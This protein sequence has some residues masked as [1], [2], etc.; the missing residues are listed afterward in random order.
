M[1]KFVYQTSVTQQD[2]SYSEPF[3]SRIWTNSIVS[4]EYKESQ[5]IFGYCGLIIYRIVA[6]FMMA[7]LVAFSIV[8]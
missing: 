5:H 1:D 8:V 3:L 6:A 2:D 7:G 4:Y